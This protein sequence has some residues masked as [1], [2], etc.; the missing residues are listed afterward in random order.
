M[1][2]TLVRPADDLIAVVASRLRG[3]GKDYSRNWVVFPERRP[4]TYLRK[5]LGQREKSAFI[6]PRVN[7]IDEFVNRV[8]SE[9]LGF[10]DHPL[11]PLDAVALLFE[12]HRSS[13][14]RL[15]LSHFL[16]ADQF[17]PLG[18]KL[19]SDLEELNSAAV[20]GEALLSVDH[21]ADE[22][23]PRETAVKLASLAHFYEKFY[24]TLE[25]MGYSTQSSRL[26]RVVERAAPEL[27][28]DVDVMIFAGFFTLT[29]MET[30]LLKTAGAWDKSEVILLR[31]RGIERL[32]DRFGLDEDASPGGA[33]EPGPLP[34]LQFTRSADTHGQIFALNKALGI[35]RR[36]PRTLNDKQVIVLPASETLFPLY[37]QTL[38]ALGE[39]DFNISMGYPLSRTPI[40]SFFDN[41]FELIQTKDDEGRIYVP[42]YLRFVLHPY[43]KNIYFSGTARRSDLTRILFHAIEE[44]LT[45]RRTRSFWT[46]DELEGDAEIRETI[47]SLIRTVEDAPVVEAC[48]DHLRSIHQQTIRLFDE[49]RNVGDFAEKLA[50][51]LNYIYENSTA[52]L[53]YFFHPYAEAFLA[54]LEALAR[55]LLRETAFAEKPSYFNLLRKVIDAGTVPFYGTPLKGMQVLGFWE[56][57]CI[58]FED[59]YV[60]D[61][62]EGAIPSYS[63]SDSLLPFAVRQALGL[64][65]YRDREAR[66]E[67][68]LDTLLR[69]AGR[70][71]FFFVEND[72]KE[73][74]RFVER[75]LWEK[76]KAEREPRADRFLK[77]VRYEIALSERKPRSIEKSA[78]VG[79]YLREFGHSATSLD[80]YLRC[81]LSFYY[82]HVLRLEEKEEMTES[83]ER[84]DI[85]AFVHAALEEFFGK[86]VGRR[87]RAENLDPKDLDGL[88][89]RKFRLEYGGDEA[90]SAYLTK[91]QVRRHL[92]EFIRDYQIPVIRDVER[93]AGELRLL[94]VEQRLQVEKKIGRRSFKLS[95]RIDRTEQRGEMFYILDYKTSSSEKPLGINFKKLVL[96]DRRTWSRAVA[97]VQIP[98]YRMI[99]AQAARKPL[100]QVRG[101]FVLLGKNRLSPRIEFSPYHDEDPD[102]R[103]EEIQTTDALIERLL[104]EIADPATP[105]DPA[106]GS[107]EDCSLCPYSFICRGT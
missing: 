105:F 92:G 93:E 39:D 17:F 80:R 68:Y 90:G 28:A 44:E 26:R 32:L 70:V 5:A 75:L 46:L 91:L 98:L 18:S 76:Q 64:P 69:A 66:T 51:V 6:S 27:F 40:A 30:E 73:K 34:P 101:V 62:N 24:C 3:R 45:R 83:L 87:L 88:V 55:S 61:A 103:R 79:E 94:S 43:T 42:S 57:R 37:Q 106:L 1:R 36:D 14:G 29:R 4:S 13:P 72:D 38:S 50:L 12:I 33:E 53:H 84:K 78:E 8:Y 74:S 85:G 77:T 99:Y 22:A 21:W 2:V 9:R 49:V 102:A 104:V 47:Q 100:G 54:R 23:V 81:P 67:Y 11:D 41:L 56:A 82:A 59:V 60:L 58:P 95:A 19:F 63:R 89:D 97:S 16:T 52:R 15:G 65:T 107:V 35:E 20:T 86:F 71:H 96:E 7:S 10:A 48:L 25:E 31:G